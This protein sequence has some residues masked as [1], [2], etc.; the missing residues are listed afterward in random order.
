MPANAANG[1]QRLGL[2]A[3]LLA[4]FTALC[5]VL[6]M[7]F[8]I[9][10]LGGAWVAVFGK[11]AAFSAYMIGVSLILVAAAWYVALRRRSAGNVMLFLATST[12]LTLAAWLVYANEA[13]LN[14]RLLAWM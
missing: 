11:V 3:A 10:G 7:V 8:I 2:G 5:C 9:A 4:F 14:D 12:G 13:A 1:I 6:P